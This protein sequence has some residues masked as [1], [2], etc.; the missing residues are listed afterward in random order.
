[1]GVRHKKF[2]IEGVQYHPESIVS[3]HGRKMFANFLSWS[4]GEWSSLVFQPGV[5]N[6]DRVGSGA[7]DDR[8]GD[9]VGCE[10]VGSGMCVAS[11]S[12]MNSTDSTIKSTSGSILDVI[13]RQRVLDVALSKSLPGKSFENLERSIALGLAPKQIDFRSR[14][15]KDCSDV[16]V[17]AEIKRASPSKGD[18]DIS[19]H[20]PSQ[21]ILYSRGGASVISVLTEPKW[22]KGSLEVM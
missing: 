7:G 16:A 9:T 14:I 11:I 10:K 1:M 4:G 6:W 13:H 5:V 21:A 2:I 20:A 22:F 17:M 3:Q 8:G 19:I 15:L 12:K 18:I